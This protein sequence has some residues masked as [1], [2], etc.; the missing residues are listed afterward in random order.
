MV[1]E[2][3]QHYVNEYERL[4]GA[5][6]YE[7]YFE[8]DGNLHKIE[9]AGITADMVR[10]TTES[11]RNG[12]KEKLKLYVNAK[13]KNEWLASGKAR[14]IMTT[15]NFCK[16]ANELGYNKGQTC[17]Y[18]SAK[19][20][21]QEFKL[22]NVRFDKAGDVNLKRKKIQ[23]KFENASLTALSTIDKVAAGM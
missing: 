4:S 3:L 16:L 17:E 14:K 18:L 15:N 8:K 6:A 19:A 23:V 10:I 20:R 21:N 7:I 12:G 11:E 2:R 22:D 1:N 13:K 5:N 9:L